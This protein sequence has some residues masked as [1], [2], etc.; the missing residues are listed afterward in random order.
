MAEKD[1]YEI[2]GVG[3]TASTD[4]IRKAYR[5]LAR[6][7]HPDVNPN[8]AKA[9]DRFKDIS[10]AHEVLSDEKKRKLFDE[11]G[12]TG[13]EAGFDPE[14]A[15]AYKRWSENSQRSPFHQ[16][17]SS[18]IDLEDLLGGLYGSEG[19]FGGGGFSGFGRQAPRGPR[20]GPDAEGEVT[21]DFLDAVRGG[22][23]PLRFDNKSVEVTIPPGAND[24]TR[25]RLAGQ[26]G[27]G[28]E[29]GPAGDLY[30]TLRVRSHPFFRREGD[31][32][33][34]EVPVT[35]PEL[36]LGGSIQ[37]PTPDGQA[38]VK[39]PPRSSNGRKLRLR[40]KGARRREG[41][42]GDLYVTLSA[43]LPEENDANADRLEEVA[44]S[45]EPL[46]S[47][48]NVRENIGSAA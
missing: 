12:R 45:M 39:V 42:H 19:G 43:V 4:E 44:R 3:K 37:V 21:I 20:R 28:R 11:F 23:V 10:F 41:G 13:L 40:G 18:E 31:D 7:H 17:F 1:L 27:E 6:K 15:R 9:A 38:A 32:L 36:I 47:G 22:K 5:K 2:L 30:L 34:V 29:G 24:G 33:H 35:V 14:Q 46:Y 26:G 8:D 48:R 16:S 25:I